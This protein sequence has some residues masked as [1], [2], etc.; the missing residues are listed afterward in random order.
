MSLIEFLRYIGT[1]AGINAV[2]GFILSFAAEW[3]PQY[4]TLT[5]RAKRLIMMVLCFVVPLLSLLGLIVVGEEVLTL[6]LIWSALMAG[7][8][9]FFGSQ[10]AHARMLSVHTERD[11]GEKATRQV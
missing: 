9:A 5:P 6:E 1:G 8:A 2:I 3:W 4:E 10:V 11:Q 7:F